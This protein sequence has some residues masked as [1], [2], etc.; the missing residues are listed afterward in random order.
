MGIDHIY[1][2]VGTNGEKGKEEGEEEWEQ[3]E[4]DLFAWLLC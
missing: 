4:R 1:H 2:N 3:G